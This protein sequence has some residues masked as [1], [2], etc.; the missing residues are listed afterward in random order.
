VLVLVSSYA[1]KIA[2]MKR[3]Q[4]CGTTELNMVNGGSRNASEVSLDI[5]LTFTL[6]EVTTR[7]AVW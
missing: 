5:Y 7:V 4:H 1:Q 6:C 2:F 3:V